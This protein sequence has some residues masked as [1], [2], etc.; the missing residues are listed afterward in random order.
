M[1]VAYSRNDWKSGGS[2]QAQMCEGCSQTPGA[3]NGTE[4]RR[5]R[6][7]SENN[8]VGS[9]MRSRTQLASGLPA[10]SVVGDA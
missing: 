6:T 1:K 5:R 9:G 7:E 4:T 8:P 10:M 3:E 2:F